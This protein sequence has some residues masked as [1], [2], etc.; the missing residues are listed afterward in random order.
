M[1]KQNLTF[2]IYKILNIYVYLNIV[3]T[4]LMNKI[5]EYQ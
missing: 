5:V 1:L 3:V 4:L 2:K